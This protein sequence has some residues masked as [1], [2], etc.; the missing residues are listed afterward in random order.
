MIRNIIISLQFFITAKTMKGKDIIFFLS[1][2]DI[3]IL[4][5]YYSAKK[6]QHKPHNVMVA[7]MFLGSPVTEQI[8]TWIIIVSITVGIL[9]LILI[10]LALI[11]IG[12]FNRKKKKELDALKSEINVS[13]L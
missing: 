13:L 7:T 10:I 6:K 3:D 1:N 5:S 11:K 2:G 9:L 8:A 4:E 12:F